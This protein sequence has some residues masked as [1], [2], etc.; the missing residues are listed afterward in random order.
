MKHFG[1]SA[2]TRASGRPARFQTSSGASPASFWVLSTHHDRAVAGATPRRVLTA[3]GAAA[4]ALIFSACSAGTSASSSAPRPS[5]STSSLPPT[6]TS[7]GRPPGMTLLGLGDSVPGA[8]G[9]CQD[10]GE[11]CRSYVLVLADLASKATGKPVTAVN[12]AANND[13]TS[14]SLLSSVETDTAMREAIGRAA[15]ITIQVGNNDWQG[16]CVRKEAAACLERNRVKVTHNIG[17]ILDRVAMLRGGSTKGVR[18]VAY[19]DTTY[20]ID[21]IMA[22]WEVDGSTTP[23]QLHAMFTKALKSLNASTCGGPSAPRDLCGPTDCVQRPRW[24]TAGRTRRDAP[25]CR[26]AREDRRR[27]RQG[28]IRGHHLELHGT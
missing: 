6:P 4:A 11:S 20:E 15:L 14:A 22:D 26:R 16:P 25:R 2:A 7:T 24:D 19:A 23:A 10:M 12:M 17:R 8:G 9:A 27:D 13:V 3:L 18:I 28:R 5:Q 21:T 1:R